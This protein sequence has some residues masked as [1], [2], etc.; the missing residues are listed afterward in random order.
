MS[1]YRGDN[2][3]P[4]FIEKIRKLSSENQDFPRKILND[5]GYFRVL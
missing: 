2:Q 4:A 1:V 5:D 3:D